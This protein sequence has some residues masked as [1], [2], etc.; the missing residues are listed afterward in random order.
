MVDA[1]PDLANPGETDF[2]FDHLDLTQSPPRYDLDALESDGD[3]PS[4]VL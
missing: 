2:L 3:T 1:H 4:D